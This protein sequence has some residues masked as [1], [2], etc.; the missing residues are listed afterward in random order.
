MRS[1]TVWLS[2][3]A[4]A[5][6][7]HQAPLRALERRLRSASAE[8]EQIRCP[9][10]R[11][12]A[13]DVLEAGDAIVHFLAARHKSLPLPTTTRHSRRLRREKRKGRSVGSVSADVR[14]EFTQRH[15]YTTGRV[16]FSLYSD[17]A[18]FDAPDPD[19]PVRS[20]RKFADALSGLFDAGRSRCDLLDLH[21][22][23]DDTIVALWRLEGVLR[24]PWRPRIKPFVG[25]TTYHLDQDRLVDSHV[26]KWS[27]TAF[28]AFLSA[29]VDDDFLPQFRPDPAPPSDTLQQDLAKARDL[30]I[31]R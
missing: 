25:E 29:I 17:E 6:G 7:F 31:R 20:P 28:D 2:L 30:I 15:Y 19:M 24:L 9:F 3:L 5:V 13:T 1:L 16:D 18:L 26:E 4:S 8:V 14:L 27:V 21:V 12:R 10:F 22:V 11:R 23:D